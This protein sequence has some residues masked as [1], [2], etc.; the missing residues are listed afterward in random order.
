LD[1]AVTQQLT[2][3][4]F[5]KGVYLSGNVYTFVLSRMLFSMRT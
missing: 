1:P 4:V 5:A 2:E 3:S